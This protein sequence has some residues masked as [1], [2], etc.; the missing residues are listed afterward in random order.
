[1]SDDNREK[2][3][4]AGIELLARKTFSQIS[5]D[6]VA[7]SSGVSKPMIYYYFK[8]KEGYYRSLAEYLLKVARST[9][10]K[11][12]DSGISLR[13]NL[14][15]YV[16]FRIDY[17]EKNPGMANAFLSVI[18]DPNIGLLI[19]QLQSEFEV[20]RLEFIDP[21]FD[22]AIAEGEIAPGTNRI[23]VMMMLNSAIMAI[24][25]KMINGIEP[26]DEIDPE[27]IVE[28]IFSGI[29]A[30]ERTAE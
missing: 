23:A 20:M 8:N 3:L 28:V 30:Q 24:T 15:K 17:V 1:L 27:E 19:K 12:Y 10:Q 14:K 2:L 16:R 21:M 22:K 18:M 26:L 5:M 13:G 25:V 7:E 29:S 6:Q 11:L 4:Q 9:M